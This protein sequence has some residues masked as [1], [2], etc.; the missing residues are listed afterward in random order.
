[1]NNVLEAIDDME[2][3]LS[4]CFQVPLQSG[5]VVVRTDVMDEFIT[6]IRTTL[7]E[8]IKRAN[9]IIDD[10]EH[11]MSIAQDK[12]AVIEEE[13]M[14][15]ANAMVADH[16]ITRRAEEQAAALLEQARRESEEIRNE[17]YRYTDELLEKAQKTIASLLTRSNSDYSQFEKTLLD[18]LEIIEDNR[19]ALKD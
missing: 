3:Y 14:A 17:A 7:P 11:M 13:A 1:M 15:K 18:Q 16:E 8:E 4:D 5:K 19:E 6:K 10:R 12:L 2:T 9:A